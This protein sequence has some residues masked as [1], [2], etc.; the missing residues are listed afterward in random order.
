MYKL[1]Q[2][3]KDLTEMVMSEYEITDIEF[4]SSH[5]ETATD[6]RVIVVGVLIREGWSEKEICKALNWKQQRVNFLKNQLDRRLKRRG[7]RLMLES[8]TDLLK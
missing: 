7:V 6:A 5:S 4:E 2:F 3:M 1:R 8:I